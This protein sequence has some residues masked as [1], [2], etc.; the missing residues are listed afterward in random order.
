VLNVVGGRIQH[1]RDQHLAVG[2]V[3]L[4]EQDPLMRVTWVGRLNGDRRWPRREDEIND[5]SQRNIVG[6]WSLVVAPAEMQAHSFRG[7]IAGGM[8]E[9]LY[10]QV[11]SAAKLIQS[12]VMMAEVG[13]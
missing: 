9:R 13:R 7:D 1:A 12:F 11:D 2:E 10:M 6:M 4:L 8:V 3:D 5:I